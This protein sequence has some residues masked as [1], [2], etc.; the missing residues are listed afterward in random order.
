MTQS[1]QNPADRQLRVQAWVG[2]VSL[3]M[4][5]VEEWSKA[6]GWTIERSV[7][8]IQDEPLGTYEVPQLHIQL[9]DAE[10]DVEPITADLGE[11]EGRVDLRSI[12]TFS[13]VKLLGGEQ[14]RIMTDSNVP[15][16][17]PWTRETFAQLARDL[18]A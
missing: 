3:L 18:V 2:H 6:E 5:Q 17:L 8:T 15:L 10:L 12:F 7:A 1:I 9:P 4:D 13:R 11:G 16:R 14:W